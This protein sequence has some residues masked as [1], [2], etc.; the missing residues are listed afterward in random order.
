MVQPTV[1]GVGIDSR[2]R[3]TPGGEVRRRSRVP[4][5]PSR[6]RRPESHGLLVGDGVHGVVSEYSTSSRAARRSWAAATSAPRGSVVVRGHSSLGVDVVVLHSTFPFPFFS[7]SSAF[8]L[9]AS[10]I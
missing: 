3:G 6:R 2:R 5:P 8:P 10:L 7:S 1:V 4:Q 9:S